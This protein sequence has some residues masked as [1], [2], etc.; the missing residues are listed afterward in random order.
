MIR[1]RN[2]HNWIG[3]T[4]DFYCRVDKREAARANSNTF[5]FIR[6][7]LC[8][9]KWCLSSRFRV[10]WGTIKSNSGEVNVNRVCWSWL[11]QKD[12]DTLCIGGC[13]DLCLEF[14]ILHLSVNNQVYYQVS[15]RDITI[16]VA[17]NQL[18]CCFMDFNKNLKDFRGGA[19]EW[20]LSLLISLWQ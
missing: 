13:S 20:S 10:L 14:R 12:A 17:L 8:S 3:K 4:F 19:K 7:V 15:K 11:H 9:H 2:V 1:Q 16:V 6:A 18:K 5:K